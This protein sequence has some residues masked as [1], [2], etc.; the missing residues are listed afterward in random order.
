MHDL[1]NNIREHN[2]I[3]HIIMSWIEEEH[4]ISSLKTKSHILA[5]I[6]EN[7]KRMS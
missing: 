1:S 6:Q 2:I 7:L 3:Q 4:C 5:I